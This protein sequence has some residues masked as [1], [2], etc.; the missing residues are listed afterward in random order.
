MNIDIGPKIMAQQSWNVWIDRAW[1]RSITTHPWP[2]IGC[3]EIP[4]TS[5]SDIIQTRT[6]KLLEEKARQSRR[7][8][9]TVLNTPAQSRRR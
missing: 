2:R 9:L 8:R 5:S 6:T 1:P 3:I 7:S 4:T